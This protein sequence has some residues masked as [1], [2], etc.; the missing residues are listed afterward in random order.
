[1]TAAAALTRELL[2]VVS[3]EWVGEADH[4]EA[5]AALL[6]AGR[7]LVSLVDAVSFVLMRR[8]GAESAFTIDPHF[9]REGF[10]AVGPKR[11]AGARRSAR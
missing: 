4:R 2:P 9:E 11:M 10:R 1:M 7:C 5:A 3:V 8:L 6:A